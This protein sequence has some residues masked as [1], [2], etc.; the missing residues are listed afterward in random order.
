MLIGKK[1]IGKKFNTKIVKCKKM[2]IVL[3]I[4]LQFGYPFDNYHKLL[5][6]NLYSKLPK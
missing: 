2:Y 6:G 4:Y 1:F 5:H 3:A